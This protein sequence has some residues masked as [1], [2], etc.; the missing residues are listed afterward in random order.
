VI[1]VIR[2]VGCA[3]MALVVALTIGLASSVTAPAPASATTVSAMTD[4]STPRPSPLIV[5]TTPFRF[6]LH[7]IEAVAEGIAN[8]VE[9]IATPA[10]ITVP[11]LQTST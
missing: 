7:V 2:S 5:L 10:P 8:A 3:V 4:V 9:M 11:A 1:R 6:G